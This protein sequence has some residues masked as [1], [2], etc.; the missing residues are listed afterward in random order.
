M[1]LSE[2]D[3]VIIDFEG[4]PALPMDERRR[5]N[6]P[7]RD[8][9]SM[10]RSFHYAAG[11]ALVRARDDRAAGRRAHD[12]LGALVAH[13][14]DRELPGAYRCDRGRRGV[15]ARRHARPGALL[16]LLLLEQSLTEIR[17]EL[18]HRPEYV[19]IPLQ[20]VLDVI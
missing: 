10:V 8:V 3:Y 5:L 13:L 4:D 2:A 14:D 15:P 16:K 20:T 6:T 12:G 18:T 19:W 7:L 9:A 1:L 11:V 17:R